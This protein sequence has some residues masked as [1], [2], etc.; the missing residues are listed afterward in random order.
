MK[1]IKLSTIKK[2]LDKRRSSLYNYGPL[3]SLEDEL[4][5]SFENILLLEENILDLDDFTMASLAKTQKHCSLTS[6]TRVLNYYLKED[7]AKIYKTVE[8]IGLRSFYHPR[9]GTI[10]IGISFIL[11]RS[12]KKFSLRLKARGIYFWDF[13]KDIKSNIDK[14]NPLILNILRGFYR[15]HT[16][17]ILGYRVYLLDNQLHYYLIIHDGWNRSPRYIDYNQFAK[18]TI[19]SI[20]KIDGLK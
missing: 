2:Y 10:P 6:I 13:Y 4:K 18:K 9:I 15:K 14:K 12:F 7:P 8:K 11:N 20:N 17:T 1:F 5:G 3:W 16:V 19:A